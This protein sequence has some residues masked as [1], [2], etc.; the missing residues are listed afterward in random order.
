MAE[1]IGFGLSASDKLIDKH[2]DKLP[3][4]LISPMGKDIPYITEMMHTQTGT[5]TVHNPHRRFPSP[6]HSDSDP[7]APYHSSG[8]R[9]R[10]SHRDDRRSR[11]EDTRDR[12]N[13][14]ERPER[15]RAPDMRRENISPRPR[16]ARVASPPSQR[17]A[18]VTR[19]S[20][21]MRAPRRAP[22]RGDE[23]R[24]MDRSR[25]SSKNRRRS[26]SRSSSSEGIAGRF[27][28]DPV[29]RGAM[30]VAVG[31]VLAKQAV[32]AGDK[33]KD[34]GKGKGERK[35]KDHADDEILVTLAGMALGGVG[36]LFAGDK[37]KEKKERDER[38]ERHKRGKARR[39]REGK[40]DEREKERNTQ[41]WVEGSRDGEVERYMREEKIVEEGR[42]G[43]FYNRRGA[44]DDN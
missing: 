38:E 37:Y 2:F 6:P 17:P 12:D 16:H 43:D 22:R 8:S 34:R 25:D 5:N 27:M 20:Q 24:R 31:G 3:D 19:R 40:R 42:G 9:T 7:D 26:R 30:G 11:R 1:L 33:W 23:G 13:H 21:S 18:F 36:L 4:K 32:K 44:Y 15:H 14:A 41:E 10:R 28:D 29:A 39:E 35:G